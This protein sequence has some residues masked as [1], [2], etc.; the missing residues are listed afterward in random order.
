MGIFIFWD[1]YVFVYLLGWV[2]LFEILVVL[3]GMVIN[4]KGYYFGRVGES[5][6]LFG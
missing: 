1:I 4:W 6:G 5:F 3:W 2:I